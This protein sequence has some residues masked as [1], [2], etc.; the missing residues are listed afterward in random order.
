MTLRKSLVGHVQQLDKYILITRTHWLGRRDQGA[1]L[2]LTVY[3]GL[4]L[5]TV[6]LKTTTAA[7]AA[8]G[9]RPACSR[10]TNTYKITLAHTSSTGRAEGPGMLNHRNKSK[11]EDKENV[12]RRTAAVAPY[13]YPQMPSILWH[14]SMLC[15]AMLPLCGITVVTRGHHPPHACFFALWPAAHVDM[16]RRAVR[17]AAFFLCSDNALL[18]GAPWCWLYSSALSGLLIDGFALDGLAHVEHAASRGIVPVCFARAWD[19]YFARPRADP[20]PGADP[21]I[22]QQRIQK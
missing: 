17:I 9:L 15:C 19:G 22:Q 20:E 6:T 4:G 16:V 8:M 14:C 21:R 11:N 18:H 10:I 3:V 7:S 1:L 2:C 5:N 13:V 12:E